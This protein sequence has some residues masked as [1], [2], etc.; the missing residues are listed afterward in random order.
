M[1][2]SFL[3]QVKER[4]LC[5]SSIISQTPSVNVPTTSSFFPP[6]KSKHSDICDICYF[7]LSG[8]FN[9]LTPEALVAS[10]YGSLQALTTAMKILFHLHSTGYSLVLALRNCFASCPRHLA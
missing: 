10:D 3:I 9:A 4:P 8:V 1:D 7:T 6:F 2:N 5:L